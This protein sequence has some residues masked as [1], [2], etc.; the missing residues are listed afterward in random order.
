M[1]VTVCTEVTVE[2]CTP[3]PFASH[4]PTN[5]FCSTWQSGC[6]EYSSAS[7]QKDLG[8]SCSWRRLRAFPQ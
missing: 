2:V 7:F 8:A 3:A 1:A 5:V 6:Q 4:T